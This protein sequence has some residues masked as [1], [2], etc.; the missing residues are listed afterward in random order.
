MQKNIVCKCIWNHMI[1]FIHSESAFLLRVYVRL[2]KTLH[3]EKKLQLVTNPFVINTGA[4]T[5]ACRRVSSWLPAPSKIKPGSPSSL[6][7]LL[8]AP[9]INF[10]SPCSLNNDCVPPYLNPCT[11]CSLNVFL[12]S[13]FPKLLLPLCTP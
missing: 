8:D 12:C 13:L 2:Q 3:C 6:N 7:Y 10:Q 5:G 9:Q 1:M 4:P 11:Q